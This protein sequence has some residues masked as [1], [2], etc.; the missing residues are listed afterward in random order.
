MRKLI[1]FIFLS[2][3]SHACCGICTRGDSILSGV[4]PTISVDNLFTYSTVATPFVEVL[5]GTPLTFNGP[6]LVH[7]TAITEL[8]SS[9]FLLTK[10]GHY[11]ATFVGYNLSISADGVEF[12]LNGVS[13]GL[14]IEGSPL[15]LNQ[16]L[17]VT[18]VPTT[19]QVVTAGIGLIFKTGTAA[20]L[21]I[22]LLNSP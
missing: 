14:P 4:M 10:P 17:N 21:S 15:V 7:G 12:R 6:V 9:T 1:L 19:L 2:I 18:T 3:S 8:N 5:A 11:L 16:I 20:T 22:V 13:Q